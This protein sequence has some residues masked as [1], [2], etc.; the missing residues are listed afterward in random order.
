MKQVAAFLICI[1][2]LSASAER[3]ELR[4]CS[5]SANDTAEN[6]DAVTVDGPGFFPAA[7]GEQRSESTGWYL[8]RF[9]SL[10]GS[11]LIKLRG[12]R[13]ADRT[14]VNGTEVGSTGWNGDTAV[15]AYESPR[16][17]AI[18]PG[19]LREKGNV[20]AVHVRAFGGK[21]RLG[22]APELLSD[23]DWAAELRRSHRSLYPDLVFPAVFLF[24]AVYFFYLWVHFRANLENLYFAVYC[25]LFAAYLITRFGAGIFFDASST[26]TRIEFF[27]LFVSPPLFLRF[28]FSFLQLPFFKPFYAFEVLCAICC[29]MLASA[30]PERWMQALRG[31]QYSLLPVIIVTVGF[32]VRSIRRGDPE[33]RRLGWAFGL[34]AVLVAADLI[35]AMGL[36]PL[37]SLVPYG[38]AALLFAI[39]GLLT[40]RYVKLYGAQEQQARILREL[41]QR[42]NE[43]LSNISHELKTPLAEIM[44]FAELLADRT[45]SEPAEVHDAHQEIEKGA[46]RLR[47]LVS[48]TVLLNLLETGQYTLSPAVRKVRPLAEEC[49]RSVGGQVPGAMERVSLSI[50][51]DVE[52]ECDPVLFERALE[53]LIENA[54]LY[55]S[56]ASVRVWIQETAAALEL[57][58]EDAG[59]GLPKSVREK[60]FE[61]FIRGDSSNTYAIPGTG[62]GLALAYLSAQAM[63][64]V[65]SLV[66]TGPEGTRFC[67]RFERGL[68]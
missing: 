2:F 24:V 17:Y 4:D 40:N 52:I 59:K 18:G 64:A 20:L 26:T 66:S 34:F 37:P 14:Y 50:P 47:H 7:P 51:P 19:V 25:V 16:I 39:A 29:V 41:D 63:G 31:F 67:L 9:D 28:F 15:I 68:S 13:H 45:L 27:C 60:L 65:L 53:N 35:Q 48:D 1:P 46:A 49:V 30:D 11:L 36:L 6:K 56:G 44:L 3:L 62:T 5:F 33:A 10:P 12:V 8:C 21:L 32:L 43:F 23:E 38:F 61:K 58:V 54:V 57:Y 22:A 55:T 42:K